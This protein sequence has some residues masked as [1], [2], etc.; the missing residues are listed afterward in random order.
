MDTR[1][2][3][4]ILAA[5]GVLLLLIGIATAFLG[6]L[7]MYCFYLFS[8]GG[9][10]HYE[11]FGF[12]SFMFGNIAA[13]IVGYYL[14]GAVCILLGYGHLRARRWT[15]VLALTLIRSWLVVGAPLAI[16]LFFILVGSKDLSPLA[17]LVAAILLALSYLAL[18]APLIRFYQ[19]HDVRATLETRNPA[20]SFIE[21]FPIPLL[22]LS[23]LYLFYTVVLHIAILFNGVFPLFG[24]FLYGLPGIVVLD[25]AIFSLVL[26]TWGTLRARMWAWWASLAIF[27]LITTS[28]LATLVGANYADILAVL[29]FPPTEIDILD[30]LP[31]QGYHLAALVGMPLVLTL[32]TIVLS[33]RHFRA[34]L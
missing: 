11:G 3:T 34:Q 29:A 4:R 5:I 24:T 32:A 17:A 28:T 33:R 13:Q 20:P 16:I 10:F 21:S 12:G 2:Q 6:P 8:D 7:E 19:S 26:L 31:I 18:P 9:R 25:I 1:D 30:G 22:V 27:A 14:I 23:T 15:R